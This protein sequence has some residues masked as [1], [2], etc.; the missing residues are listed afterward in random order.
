MAFASSCAVWVS[1]SWLHLLVKYMIQKSGMVS[2]IDSRDVTKTLEFAL[3]GS[4]TWN[5][6][7]NSRV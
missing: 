6:T 5:R 2:R 1:L 4:G 7:K 3:T